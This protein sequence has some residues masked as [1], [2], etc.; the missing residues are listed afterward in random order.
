MGTFSKKADLSTHTTSTVREFSERFFNNFDVNFISI[1]SAANRYPQR[2]AT[3]NELR[4][5]I[6]TIGALGATPAMSGSMIAKALETICV[7]ESAYPIKPLYYSVLPTDAGKATYV[8]VAQISGGYW[9]DA[10]EY[11]IGVLGRR[12]ELPVDRRQASIYIQLM[13]VLAYMQR[14]R[15]NA[16]VP[17][18]VEGIY[19]VHNQ[20][21]NVDLR[22]ISFKTFGNQSG[23]AQ[24]TLRLAQ[25]QFNG[26][27]QSIA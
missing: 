13:H 27:Q 4:G 16:K 17:A 7:I 14:Y 3:A 22:R 11:L 25:Q 15:N 5:I 10:H 24:R 19:A 21:F 26:Q 23:D 2:S 12:P 9:R 8:G 20:G 18:T 6:Q 1:M